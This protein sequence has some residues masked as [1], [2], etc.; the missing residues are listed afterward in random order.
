[1]SHS[2]PRQKCACP[3]SHEGWC[4]RPRGQEAAGSGRAQHLGQGRAVRPLPPRLVQRRRRG[5]R[6]VLQL[7]GLLGALPRRPTETPSSKSAC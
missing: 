7:I 5:L 3:F 1:M 4:T 6:G 2:W